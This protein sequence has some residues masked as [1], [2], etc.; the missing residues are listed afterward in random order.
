MEQG[1]SSTAFEGGQNKTE[2]KIH[3]LD[4]LS[5]PPESA[6][7]T[8]HQAKVY[9]TDSSLFFIRHQLLQQAKSSS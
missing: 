1:T 3:I 4:E 6:N 5:Q 9:L 8:M 7:P 2:F